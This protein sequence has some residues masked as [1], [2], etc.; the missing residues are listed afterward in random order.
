MRCTNCG[1]ILPDD[2]AF[3]TA[4]G[5]QV[6]KTPATKSNSKY[7]FFYGFYK[8]L[9]IIIS[10]FYAIIILFMA[11]FIGAEVGIGWFFLIVLF[12]AI[13]VAITWFILSLCIAPK[14][15]LI[16]TVLEIKKNMTKE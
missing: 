12:G 1:K 5:E 16:D 11:I 8:K 7:H 9:P 13:L 2:S 6:Y 4:C 15:V 10:I 3:C 14:V